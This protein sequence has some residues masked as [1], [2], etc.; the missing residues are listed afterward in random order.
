MIKTKTEGG[1]SKY[2]AEVHVPSTQS[3]YIV[4]H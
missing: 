2:E 4:K 3:I 1:R